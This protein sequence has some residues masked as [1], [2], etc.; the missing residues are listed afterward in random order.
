MFGLQ[1]FILVLLALI[2]PNGTW[3]LMVHPATRV[4]AVRSN[5]HHLTLRAPRNTDLALLLRLRGG[6]ASTSLGGL[7][8]ALGLDASDLLVSGER[9]LGP[10]FVTSVFVYNTFRYVPS[11]FHANVEWKQ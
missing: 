5:H 1:A 2:S 4:A 7:E 11:F 6:G 9:S 8:D 10:L 3:A